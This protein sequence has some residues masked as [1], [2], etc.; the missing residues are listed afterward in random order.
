MLTLYHAPR[1]RS[2]AIVVL[3][4]ELGAQND[5][6]IET[7]NIPRVDG[8]GQRDPSNPHPEG[9]APY[10]VHDGHG[11]SE[12]GAII[13]YLT[14]M[15]P[16]AGL[17]PL[18][19]D[20]MRGEYLSWLSWYQGVMEPVLIFGHMGIAH[21]ALSA[22][23]RGIPEMT[24]RLSAALKDRPYLLGDRFSGADL[25]IHSP[26]VFFEGST[27]DDPNIRA[28]VARCADRPAKWRAKARDDAAFANAA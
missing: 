3:I 6:T 14:D 26:F 10:L 27:P 20:P 11:I 7:V 23:F 9:K 24:A 5:V 12:R 16:K 17:G 1:S 2:S 22:T 4:D 13:L 18:P 15:F 28:W 19:G 21:P 8:T 25:L